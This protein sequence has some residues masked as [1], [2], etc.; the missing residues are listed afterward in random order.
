M[1]NLKKASSLIKIIYT[2]TVSTYLLSGTSY[3][4]KST[5]DIEKLAD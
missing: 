5:N 2:Y 3:M 4:V 1:N